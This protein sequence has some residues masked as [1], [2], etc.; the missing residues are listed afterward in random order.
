MS[1]QI[2]LAFLFVAYLVTTIAPL[3]QSQVV[4]SFGGECEGTAFEP[5]SQV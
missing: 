2:L 4:A 5:C 3:S 1:R